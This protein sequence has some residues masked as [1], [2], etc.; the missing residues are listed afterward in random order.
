[1]TSASFNSLTQQFRSVE[2]A[3]QTKRSGEKL[4]HKFFSFFILS[5]QQTSP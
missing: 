4:M 2:T 5:V 1:M 3:Y